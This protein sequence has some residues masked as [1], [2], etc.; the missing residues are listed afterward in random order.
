MEGV[1]DSRK[2]IKSSGQLE[3]SKA[4]KA[5]KTAFKQIEAI[6]KEDLEDI[7]KVIED[8]ENA[9]KSVAMQ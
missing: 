9:K 3:L 5:V 2:Q 4:E 1:R 8:K 7:L 6:K